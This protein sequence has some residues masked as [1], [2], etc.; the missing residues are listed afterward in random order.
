MSTD[1]L[2][3]KYEKVGQPGGDVTDTLS[4]SPIGSVTVPAADAL[5]AYYAMGGGNPAPVSGGGGSGGGGDPSFANVL[6]LLHGDG[7]NGSAS[8]LDSSPS[9]RVVTPT[10]AVLTTADKKYGSASVAF[11]GGNQFLLIPHH[12]DFDFGSGD[13]TI[14]TWALGDT[15]L[16]TSVIYN[17]QNT[18]NNPYQVQIRQIQVSGAVWRVDV[19]SYSSDGTT[20]TTLTGTINIAYYA[21]AHIAV[22]KQG[23]TLRLFVD[24]AAAGSTTLPNI[25]LCAPNTFPA[26]VGAYSGGTFGFRGK[27]DDFRITKGVARYTAAF[28]PP[29]APFPDA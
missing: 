3:D 26:T 22:V 1:T 19:L 9:A 21:W 29:A 15:V 20:L 7:A 11:V 16:G 23:T 2:L 25:A 27:L 5:L 6:L 4:S 18:T 13:F 24:G 28:T 17:K 8:I 10:G 12:A 14:E